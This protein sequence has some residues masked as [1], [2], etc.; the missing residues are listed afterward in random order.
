VFAVVLFHLLTRLMP[1]SSGR[2]RPV[3][4]LSWTSVRFRVLYGT[5]YRAVWVTRSRP[6]VAVASS[7]SRSSCRSRQPDTFASGFILSCASPI[8]QSFSDHREPGADVQ[9]AFLGPSSLIAASSVGVHLMRAS[10]AHTV[11]SS[12]FLTSSTV[13]SSSRLCGFVSPRSHVQGSLFRGFP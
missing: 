10:R 4:H 3:D 7:S 13:S 12:T 6:D 11:P 9:T 8:L 2:H 5:T 1:L